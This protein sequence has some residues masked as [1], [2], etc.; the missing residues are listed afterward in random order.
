MRL[1][2]TLWYMPCVLFY[3]CPA[4]NLLL[5]IYMQIRTFSFYTPRLK[6]KNCYLSAQLFSRHTILRTVIEAQQLTLKKKKKIARTVAGSIRDTTKKWASV[7]SHST[8]DKATQP[9][10][11]AL[12]KQLE[13]ATF[14]EPNED[15]LHVVDKPSVDD[16]TFLQTRPRSN[17]T[18]FAGG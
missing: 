8:L 10:R 12:S 3:F 7:V 11:I 4:L 9:S 16:S 18:G 14:W 15:K 17:L 5:E 2:G 6:K 13:L 1:N